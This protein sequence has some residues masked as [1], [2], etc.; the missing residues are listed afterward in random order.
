MRKESVVLVLVLLSLRSVAVQAQLQLGTLLDDG[1]I[2]QC[3]ARA[4]VWGTAAAG[5]EVAVTFAR[6]QHKATAGDDGRWQVVLDPMPASAEGRTLTVQ[7]GGVRRE[8][9]DVLVGEVW[10]ASGQSNMEMS[11]AGVRNAKAEAAAA[12]FPQLRMFTVTKKL[13]PTPRRT[14]GGSWVPAT[15]ETVGGFSATA[16]FF[17][18]ELHQQLGVPVGIVHASWGGTPAQGWTPLEVQRAMPALKP[19]VERFEAALAKIDRAAVARARA[20][21]VAKYQVV[22]REWLDRIDQADPG[23][24]QHWAAPAYQPKGWREGHFP[25]LFDG[26]LQLNQGFIWCRKAVQIPEAW[27]GRELVVSTC[28]VDEC[29]V[30]Y[31]NGTRVGMVWY[32]A[33]DFWLVPHQFPVPAA[34]V[35]GREVTVTLRIFNVFGGVGTHGPARDL[36]VRSAKPG[37]EEQPVSLAGEWLYQPS[38][39]VEPKDVPQPRLPSTVADHAGQPSLLY[40]AMIAPLI[41]Y[42]IRGAIWYQGEANA[43]E[44][45]VYRELFPAMIRAWRQAWGQGAFPFYFVQLANFMAVQSRP[46]E[47]RSWADLRE[48]QR[49]TLAVPNT[50]MAVIT[51]IGE[52]KDIHPRNKQDV[53]RRLAL[54]ALAQT[55]G[56]RIEYSG[57]T[58]AGLKIEGNQAIVT[59]DHAAGLTAVDGPLLGFAIGGE[60]KIFHRADARIDDQKVVLSSAQVLVPVAV[61]YNWA[62]NPV[63]SLVNAAGLPASSFRTDEWPRTEV[64]AAAEPAMPP[65]AE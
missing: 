18:R 30:V 27:V 43:G 22:I 11:V 64:K 39:K 46:I 50:G 10:V 1:A 5:T 54:I 49:A 38:L 61:R 25:M 65:V 26:D 62:N 4:P 55:Y 41:P 53:G 57:P 16:Y 15:P 31:V 56:Q 33:P 52:A 35:T 44:P 21:A 45:D 24:A 47:V 34:A 58:F 40:N 13:S 51:D 17:A 3:D 59:F 2:L 28:A 37:A 20:E 9:R 14:C 7:A 42:R 36:F 19:R 8:V 29:Q 12:S 48:A 32:D 23:A 60:D 6:Q 63:G